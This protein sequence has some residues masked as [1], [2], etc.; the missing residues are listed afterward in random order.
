[1]VAAGT[2]R[3]PQAGGQRPWVGD[4][5]P[6]NGTLPAFCRIS[7]TMTPSKDSSIKAE[8]WLPSNGW[9]QKLVAVGNGGWVGT[10]SY[11]RMKGPLGL[12][13]AVASTDTGHEDPGAGFAIGHPEKVIDW[14]HRAVHEMKV[15][16][17]ALITAYYGKGAQRSYW[18]GCSTGGRQ[19]LMEVQRY[20]AD[21]D[22]VIAAAPS[23]N[24]THLSAKALWMARNAQAAIHPKKLGLLHKTVLEACDLQ[25]GVR[26][27]IFENPLRCNFDPTALACQTSDESNCLTHAEVNTAQLIYGPV[28]NPRTK[29]VVFP[30]LLP[31][32]EAGWGIYNGA[33]S[34]PSLDYYK[35]VLIQ[36][37]S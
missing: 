22:G 19:G 11:E 20:P 18:N 5:A 16:S 1:M 17:K 12:N 23:N 4:L 9:N 30:G 15:T 34:G 26:D 25:D 28:V 8:L 36:N 2:W 32:S 10:I 24:I 37:P 3:T 6:E 35:N 29:A 33:P 14:A 13:Y 7:L 27:G 21:F 31:G